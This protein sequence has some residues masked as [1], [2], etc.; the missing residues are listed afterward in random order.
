M[1]TEPISNS[2]YP[3]I[4]LKTV[5]MFSSSTNPL[6]KKKILK[7]NAAKTFQLKKYTKSK[8]AFCSSFSHVL[9]LTPQCTKIMQLTYKKRIETTTSQEN[10]AKSKL[11]PVE[12][13]DE[14]VIDLYF[15]IDPRVAFFM[16]LHFYSRS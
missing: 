3:K 15:H 13:F 9:R 16:P 12:D 10:K 14:I 4:I 7:S 6:N 5:K 11:T 1:K 2:Y 8:S